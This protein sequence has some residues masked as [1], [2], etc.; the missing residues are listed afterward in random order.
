VSLASTV[1]LVI[2]FL[3]NEAQVSE[4]DHLVYSVV[5][6]ELALEGIC[7]AVANCEA[8]EVELEGVG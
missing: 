2:Q 6:L 1:Y 3:R 5:V 7:A 8:L 4:E